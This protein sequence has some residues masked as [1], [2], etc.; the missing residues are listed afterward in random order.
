MVMAEPAAD[1]GIRQQWDPDNMNRAEDLKRQ[2]DAL[3]PSMLVE[4]EKFIKT[5]KKEDR[6]PSEPPSL[7]M[8]LAEY[9]IDDDLP[10]DLA[11]HLDHYLY[12][13]PKK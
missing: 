1:N 3:P 12:D 6:K 13:V 9:A 5:L 4:V 7:L 2:L 10:A 11:E 8:D